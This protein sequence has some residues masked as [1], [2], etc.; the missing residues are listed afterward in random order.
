MADVRQR[1][2]MAGAR[3]SYGSLHAALRLL[4]F[5]GAVETVRSTTDK[6]EVRYFLKKL[7]S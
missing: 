1:D 7:G 5:L 4:E 6:R 2:I 3:V